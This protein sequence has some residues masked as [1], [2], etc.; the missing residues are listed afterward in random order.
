MG[1]ILILMVL[2][3]GTA[4]YCT[5]TPYC[6]YHTI[7]TVLHSPVQSGTVQYSG[8]AEVTDRVD[9]SYE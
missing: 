4:L 9:F 6:T 1:G 3:K 7:R 8:V 2:A 5:S